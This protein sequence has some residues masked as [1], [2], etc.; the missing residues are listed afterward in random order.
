MQ[1]KGSKQT[2]YRSLDF[3]VGW[4]HARFLRPIS[5][6]RLSNGSFRFTTGGAGFLSAIAP[7]NT[8]KKLRPPASHLIPCPC[9][10]CGASKSMQLSGATPSS[11]TN[12]SSR[13]SG[14][15]KMCVCVCGRGGGGEPRAGR[16]I[17]GGSV[18]LLCSPLNVKRKYAPIPAQSRAAQTAAESCD[19][20]HHRSAPPSWCTT[21]TRRLLYVEQ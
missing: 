21:A 17:T 12:S 15:V 13:G 14:E 5:V 11:H 16:V 10:R 4:D 3:S 2:Q 6:L 20:A 19:R 18:A 7:S 1:K 8:P 9:E